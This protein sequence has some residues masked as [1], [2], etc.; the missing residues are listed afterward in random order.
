[1]P[2]ILVFQHVAHEILGTL[3]PLLKQSGMRIRFVNFDRT[4][5]EQPT[6]EKYHGLVVLGGWMGVYESDRY[7]HIKT[8]CHLI[9]EALKKEIPI[10]GICFGA[11]LLAH[12]LGSNVRRHTHKEVGWQKVQFFSSAK[13]DKIFSHFQKEEILFQMHGDTFDIPS[14]SVQLASSELCSSQAF[15]YGEKVY[16]LQFHLETDAA[17]IERFLNDPESRED[18]ERFAGVSAIEA[19]EKDST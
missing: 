8:E 3:T 1:M 10:L 14:N 18:A 12:T 2:K 6:I 7:S 19:I 15:R 4:P 13:E 9:E 16:G 5:E 17:K 11:Q